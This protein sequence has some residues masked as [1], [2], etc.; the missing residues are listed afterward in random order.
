M[1]LID[2]LYNTFLARLENIFCA[3]ANHHPIVSDFH[4]GFKH[5]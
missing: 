1:H 3:T 5:F 2:Y 4:I